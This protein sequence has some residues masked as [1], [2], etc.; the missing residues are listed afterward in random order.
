MT[1][2]KA[3]FAVLILS[4]AALGYSSGPRFV[5]Q[6]QDQPN[7]LGAK[8]FDR[9]LSVTN[10]SSTYCTMAADQG[11]SSV[12]CSGGEVGVPAYVSIP[13]GWDATATHIRAVSTTAEITQCAAG[14]AGSTCALGFTTGSILS[15][16]CSNGGAGAACG[17]SSAY[18]AGAGPGKQETLTVDTSVLIVNGL[19]NRVGINTAQP[20]EALEVTGD[21]KVSG[22]I[23]C[24]TLLEWTAASNAPPAASFATADTRN[25][26]PVLDFDASADE[27][28]V[29]SGVLP[30][31]YAGGALTVKVFFMATSATTGSVRWDAAFERMNTDEDADSFAS[32][33]SAT[34]ATSGTSGIIT[35]SSISLTAAQIDG[36]LA[37]EP[38]RLKITRDQDHAGDDMAGDAELVFVTVSE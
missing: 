9:H 13:V 11:A 38:F 2:T 12:S 1:K 28:A 5:D 8:E 35:G 16:E 14:T 33:Q 25:S 23:C 10:T 32:A 7:I 6:W 31:R 22:T 24:G 19:T 17:G 3:F 18:T 30:S 15:I 4:A 29:F 27:S 26:I 34:T 37:G 20:T 36:L 21:L